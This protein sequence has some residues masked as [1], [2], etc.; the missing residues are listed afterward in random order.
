MPMP[1]KLDAISREQTE[2]CGEGQLFCNALTQISATLCRFSSKCQFCKAR[3]NVVSTILSHFPLW[4]HGRPEAQ[5][6]RTLPPRDPPSRTPNSLSSLPSPLCLPITKDWTKPCNVYRIIGGGKW[7]R[8]CHLSTSGSTWANLAAVM[9][10]WC[11]D[12]SRVDPLQCKSND[13]K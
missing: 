4:K 12:S 8:C 9:S 2:R 7:R 6:K 11:L 3:N 13:I 5:F 10:I 1:V